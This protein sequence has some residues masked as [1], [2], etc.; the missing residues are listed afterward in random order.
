MEY[1]SVILSYDNTAKMS[2]ESVPF[3]LPEAKSLV[4]NATEPYTAATVAGNATGI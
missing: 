4:T 1:H 2:T 3:S